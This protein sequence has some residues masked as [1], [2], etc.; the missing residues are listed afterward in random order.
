[1]YSGSLVLYDTFL[2]L[3]VPWSSDHTEW[4]TAGLDCHWLARSTSAGR[5]GRLVTAT[6]QR[7]WKQTNYPLPEEEKQSEIDGEGRPLC[8]SPYST[9]LSQRL[10]IAK[11]E[12][13]WHNNLLHQF[14]LFFTG[15]SCF[16]KCDK[17][18]CNP[19]QSQEHSCSFN[20]GK[21][22]LM[23]LRLKAR[24]RSMSTAAFHCFQYTFGC[25]HAF[26]G[27]TKLRLNIYRYAERPHGKV[28]V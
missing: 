2:S 27:W 1:M 23:L 21:A 16:C 13:W 18:F 26:T 8:S 14:L 24:F 19:T 6:L 5:G 20:F 7:A 4:S 22:T 10:F 12:A 15:L 9:K 17:H 25:C 3:Q 28:Q 11:S